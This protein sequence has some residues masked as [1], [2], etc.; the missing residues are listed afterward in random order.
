MTTNSFTLVKVALCVRKCARVCLYLNRRQILKHFS[1]K[2]CIVDA[3]NCLLFYQLIAVF[4]S[5]L[6][7]LFICFVVEMLID[8]KK[9]LS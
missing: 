7:I 8:C 4:F 1:Y 3:R 9:V 2:I 6:R 5:L